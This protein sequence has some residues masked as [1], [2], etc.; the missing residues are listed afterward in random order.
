[1]ALGLLLSGN[2]YTKTNI[3]KTDFQNRI[4]K[5]IKQVSF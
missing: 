2:A 4:I 5:M 1:M 3:A